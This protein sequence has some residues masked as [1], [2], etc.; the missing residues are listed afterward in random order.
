MDPN[1]DN[2]A[3]NPLETTQ[4]QADSPTPA[5]ESQPQPEQSAEEVALAAMDKG[6]EEASEPAPEGGEPAPD[7][8]A[9][10]PDEAKPDDK[11]T[12]V[13]AEIAGLQL[14]EKAANR[15]REL[16][17]RVE[18][19]S[20]AL[21]AAGVEDIKSLPELVQ[22]AKNGDDLVTMVMDTGAEPE[23]FDQALH[24]LK[25]DTAAAA[26]DKVAAKA[27]FDI[28][29][30][31]VA[32]YAKML[33][34]DVQGI[35]DPLA[36]HQD[37]QDEVESGDLPRARALEIAATRN[38]AKR[39]E[40]NAQA[41]QQRLG[42][43]RQQQEAV[44]RG[45]QDILSWDADM[46]ASVPTYMAKRAALNDIVAEIRATKPPQDWLRLTTLAYAKI[47]TPEPAEPEKPPMGPVRANRST[48]GMVP[49]L[50]KMSMEAALDAAL[51]S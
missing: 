35:A 38:Q 45:R 2:P 23:H 13:E 49:D 1:K 21:K 40:D 12:D 47:P 17:G 37:L 51:G 6:I 29:Q 36:D 34:I 42:Q 33:G 25:L 32:G 39:A 15:F 27:A 11:P 46:Q 4:P 50:S 28:L 26:G 8:K 22:R 18:E 41:D 48:A 10:K 44:E 19:L 30:A 43:S 5:A 16:T 7:P 14:K 20:T 24:F 31:Q 9:A 3:D